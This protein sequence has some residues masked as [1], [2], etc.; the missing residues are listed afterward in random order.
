MQWTS[1]EE[2]FLR[3]NHMK[4]LCSEMAQI[5][6]RTE[7]AVTHKCQRLGLKKPRSLWITQSYERNPELREVRSKQFKE[8]FQKGLGGWGWNKGNIN[9]PEG[10]TKGD[11]I[12]T[13]QTLQS[14]HLAAE[15]WGITSHMAWRICTEANAMREPVGY[16]ISIHGYLVHTTGANR[17]RP[18][19]RVLVEKFLERELGYDEI[20][21][22]INSIKDD[23]FFPTEELPDLSLKEKELFARAGIG[24][25]QLLTRSQHIVL[26]HLL[27]YPETEK[28][29]R[30]LFEMPTY[31]SRRL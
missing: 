2:T 16:T 15:F 26:H 22:H 7:S 21:H 31:A 28:F 17:G 9:L 3:D 12:E 27:K 29:T 25:L 6:G 8:N 30:E 1:K 23:N 19:H 18:V 4:M 20:V 11:V 24:N 14:I 13:Y 10:I 5:L